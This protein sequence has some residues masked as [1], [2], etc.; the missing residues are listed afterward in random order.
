MEVEQ[1]IIQIMA[2]TF[3]VEAS[4]ITTTTSRSELKNWDSL[5]QLRLVMQ[6]EAEFGISFSIDDIPE[7]N[8]VEKIKTKIN[9]LK[10]L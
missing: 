4:Q 3:A 7:L 2:S 5:G 8:S 10:S 9:V 1:R 6:L